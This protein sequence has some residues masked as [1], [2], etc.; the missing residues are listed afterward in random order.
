MM[1]TITIFFED[2]FNSA[3]F[4]PN[5]QSG[6]KC[7]GM[8]GHTYRVRIEVTGKIGIKTGWV[9][10]YSRV[11]EAWDVIKKD[12]DHK[13]LNDLHGMENPT[14]EL[15]VMAIYDRMFI[16]IPGVT[17]VEVRET[18]HCGAVVRVNRKK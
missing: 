12:V 15:L 4:L 11:K 14:C 17:S 13:V 3:H 7:A 8:H 1:A 2:S 6:H 9:M 10:D 5:V 16:S 18:E